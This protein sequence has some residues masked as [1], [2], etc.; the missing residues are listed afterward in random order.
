MK[1]LICGK[2]LKDKP[3]RNRKYC[4]SKCAYR[5][6]Y[7]RNKNKFYESHKKWVGNHRKQYN[8]IMSQYKKTHKVE[9]A[10]IRRKVYLKTG[11]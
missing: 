7:P 3:I 4:S 10:I 8:A 9:M 2:K 6:Y 5:Y 1:C 11:N